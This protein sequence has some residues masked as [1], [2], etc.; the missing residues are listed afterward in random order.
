MY[1]G[2]R[3]SFSG[4][5]LSSLKEIMI[6]KRNGDVRVALEHFNRIFKEMR[7][8]IIIRAQEGTVDAFKQLKT[9]IEIRHHSE[10][11]RVL[12]IADSRI[13]KGL[14]QLPGAIG[15]CVVRDDQFEIT[16][17][18]TQNALDGFSK[19]SRSV[20]RWDPNTDPGNGVGRNSAQR[21]KE[22]SVAS[23]IMFLPHR[24]G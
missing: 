13:A 11:F 14:D 20:V 21:M 18:L 23:A 4:R 12:D 3:K 9:P 2:R 6:G 15:R 1:A 24:P 22:G 17:G 7:E 10:V 16:K 8:P 5:Q 19:G